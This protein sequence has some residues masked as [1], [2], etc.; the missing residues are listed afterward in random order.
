[1]INVLNQYLALHGRPEDRSEWA[2]CTIQFPV[3][4]QI[5]R[6]GGRTERPNVAP[7]YS[8]NVK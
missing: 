8:G 2:L 6:A 4:L 7:G 5:A 1:M 3:G